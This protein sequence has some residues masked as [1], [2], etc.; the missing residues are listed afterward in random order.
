[1]M[2]GLGSVPIWYW[3]T[4]RNLGD[5]ITPI[6]LKRT[7]GVASHFASR[8]QP[9]VLAIGSILHFVTPMSTVWG[10]GMLHPSQEIVER[11][12][13]ITAVRGPLTLAALRE[14]GWSLSDDVALGDP[15]I[16]ASRLLSVGE[17]DD[18]VAVVPH[19]SSIEHEMY[20]PIRND[21]GFR[22]VSLRD[23]T[24]APLEII[25]RARAVISE[26]LHGLIFA[27]AFQRPSLWIATKTIP[28]WTFKFQD[29]YAT[30]AHPQVE[31]VM[32]DTILQLGWAQL[33]AMAE[34]RDCTIDQQA[35]IDAF[36][37]DMVIV[38]PAPMIDF[39]VCRAQSPFIFPV[40]VD[41][42]L[43]LGAPVNDFAGLRK[44]AGRP[45]DSYQV[46]VAKQFENWAEKPYY[47]IDMAPT[48]APLSAQQL[49]V[50]EGLLDRHR[51]ID[52]I[53]LHD[54]TTSGTAGGEVFL[55]EGRLSARLMVRPAKRL[56]RM[57]RVATVYL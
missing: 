16:L 52:A 32:P 45:V 6:I 18:Y 28:T 39:E 26:S 10:S 49:I 2:T 38:P 57:K 54:R 25:A 23:N 3:N 55:P 24:L 13:Q 46:M 35:L 53:F 36:P 42:D 11:P 19:H 43:P 34:L 51:G 40:E 33:S 4:L 5:A 15:G 27:E 44:A 9:H 1:M 21:P 48:Q 37:R 7:M 14:K 20:D 31:P 50:A 47:L 30:C 17:P 22:I 29:W 12:A 56:S 8:D 41:G